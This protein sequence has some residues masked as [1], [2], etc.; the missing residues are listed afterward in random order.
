MP[1]PIKL[2]EVVVTATPLPARKYKTA[3]ARLYPKGE[4]EQTSVDSLKKVGY[5]KVIGEPMKGTN[6]YG[7]DASDRIKQLMRK[8]K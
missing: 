6:Q 1:D 7:P 8:R 3:K 2:P 4:V 5:G